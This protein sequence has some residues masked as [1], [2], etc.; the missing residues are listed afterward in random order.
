MR[1][2]KIRRSAI[3]TLALSASALASC[4]A[5]PV[6]AQDTAAEDAASTGDIIVTARRT[7]EKLQDVPISITVFNQEQLTSRN[8][9][10]ATEL[11]AYT[12]SLSLNSRYGPEKSSFAIRGFSQDLNTLPTVGVYFAEVVAP[13]LASNITSGNG[14]GPGDLFDLQNVQ[15]LK[16]PQGT[17]FGRNTT[18]GAILLVPQKPTDKFEG[19]VEGSVG[20]YDMWRAQAVV[21]VPVSETLKVRVGIDRSKRGGY[22]TNRSGIGPD[23]FG[24]SNYFAARV[25]IL[26][27]LSPDLENYTIFKYNKSDIN[28]IVPKLVYCDPGS[29]LS[30]L[31]KANCAA[32]LQREAAFGF[33]DVENAAPNPFVRSRNWQAINTTTWKT[34]DTLT[35]KNI[36]SYAQSRESYSFSL[37]GDLSYSASGQAL[38]AILPNPGP[39]KPQGNQWTLS[40]ELQF[41]GR[42][43]DG[44]LN[45]Q[46]GGYL[47]ISKP[48]G[49]PLGQQQWTIAGATPMA[50]TDLYAY[51]CSQFGAVI[52]AENTYEFSNYGLYAQATY[53]ISDQF[54]VTGGFRYNWDWEMANAHNA[55]VVTTPNGPFSVSCRRQTTPPGATLAITTDATCRHNVFGPNNP[56]P[57]K[58]SKPTWLIDI[59]YKPIPD[60][61]VYA[62]YARGY[63]AGGINE[64]NVNNETW[65]PETVDT[66]ELGVKS[67]W[68]GESVRGTFNI[69]GF[70][71]E[72]KNQQSSVFLPSCNQFGGVTPPCGATGINGIQNI[73]RSRMK[74]VEIDA[75]L[76][77]GDAFKID[78]GYA[79]LDARVRALTA[80]SFCDPTIYQCSQA[81]FVSKVGDVL[82]FAPKNRLTVTASYKLPLPESIGRLSA[83][84]T[85]T[86]TDSQFH[87]NGS[88][89]AF[90]A[91]RIPF[92]AGIVPA[93]DLLNLNLDWKAVGGSPVDAS[94]FATNVT[95]KKYWVAA[96]SGINQ[97]GGEV[98]NSR[99]S[100]HVRGAAE[101]PLRRLNWGCGQPE[102]G[103]SDSAAL[104]LCA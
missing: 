20:N 79:Y 71:N 78:M 8:I 86:H 2:P 48:V 77:F 18:G 98:D 3:R 32:Q 91:G 83:S 10:N 44:R 24:D 51:K 42:T 50:C 67:A 76:A 75:S 37:A 22:I 65:K 56:N 54:S 46:A 17:L 47:E 9:T 73:G 21:N 69:T 89:A 63:R 66:Y 93:T 5:M 34:S 57:L 33:Y 45:W 104:G 7:E 28:H 96:G 11:A 41:Q 13:R 94:L 61:L 30:A 90:A 29:I 55:L 60:I 23:K 74:G 85:F 87:I 27:D 19:Y 6:L 80:P 81:T 43:G 92:D 14:A 58:S 35:I 40:E 64:A 62:K 15:V 101:V 95:G 4:W 16:G 1:K 103:G 39:T 97:I 88:A 84:A 31:V 36:L 72:F 49:G 38:T 52:T 70:W 102:G 59:D 82:P 25:S 26:A 68:R 12:P 53:E 99:C 100:A